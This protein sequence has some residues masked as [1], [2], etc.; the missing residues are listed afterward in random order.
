MKGIILAL[1]LSAAPPAW[2]QQAEAPAPAPDYGDESAWLCL[3]GRADSCGRPLPT[4]ALNANG[5]GSTGQVAPAADAPIDCFYVY[6]TI[7]RDPTL[8]SDLEPGIEEQAAAAVQFARFASICRPFAPMYRQV[9]L[10]ALP[11]A[12]AG[13]DL[14][15]N[16]N[17]AY[18][19]VRAAWRHYLSERNQGRPFVLIGHS[20]GT[21]HLIRLLAEEIE[22]HPEAGRMLSALLIGYN[23]EVPQGAAVGG[24]FRQTPLCTAVGQTGCVVSYVSFRAASPPAAGAL[25]G[26]SVRPGMIVACTN[27]AALGGGSAP[28]DSY[29]YAG[30]SV[31]NTQTPIQWSSQGAAPTMFLRTEGLVS[32]ACVNDGPLGYLAVTVNADPADA[33]TDRIPG[34]VVIA[35]QVQ[36]GWGL[37]LA[38]V[39]LAL[40]DLLRLVEAQRDAY[41]RRR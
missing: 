28:L 8:N 29:W 36:P 18:E 3:P 15:A 16:S 12:F 9:T 11:R 31:T 1:A 17:I 5:Y 21:V 10:T 13:Q 6:P 19:D 22:G 20:Q 39:S 40:G 14:T 34:D 35:G 25:F 37:H 24:S 2:A 38:D 27:P 7:S 4:T 41:L 23:V 32:A 30:P 26:R 33:R